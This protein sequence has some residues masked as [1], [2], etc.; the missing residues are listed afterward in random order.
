MNENILEDIVAE[1]YRR[2]YEQYD[3]AP[4]HN[5]SIKHKLNMKRIFARYTRNVNKIKQT[6]SKRHFE[7]TA[8]SHSLSLRQK[9][10]V[11]VLIIVLMTLLVGWVAVYISKDFHGTVYHDYT[12][13][14]VVNTDDCPQRI[15]YRYGLSEIPAGFELSETVFSPVAV[16]TK[17]H[18]KS[19]GV[20]IGIVQGVKTH[21]DPNINTEHQKNEEKKKKPEA[22]AGP[23]TSAWKPDPSRPLAL[24]C[25]V[26]PVTGTR[27][28]FWRKKKKKLGGG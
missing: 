22:P 12:Q 25:K 24:R 26:P 18:N 1:S 23:A 13:L 9:L 20:T 8:Y 2:E 4:E 21:Y 27:E 14:T 17:Y 11:A 16:S 7:E 15:E 6:E 19:T 3:N 5:F 10:F 28:G